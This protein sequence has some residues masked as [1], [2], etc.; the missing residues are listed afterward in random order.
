MMNPKCTFFL[1][2]LLIVVFTCISATAQQQSKPLLTVADTPIA[3]KEFKRV[4]SKNLDLVKDEAQKDVDQYLQLFI[5][6]KLK[7]KEAVA[8]GLDKKQS[9]IDELAK[10]RKQLAS[11]YLSDTKV[12]DALVK[13]AY[14]HMQESV[15]ASHILIK[16]KPNA[17][18][19]DTLQ[20]YNSILQARKR[21]LDGEDFMVVAKEVSQD[22][23]VQK[24]GGDLGWFSAFRMVYPFE[25]NAYDTQVGAVSMPFK[26][27]FGY[28]ILKVN[29]RR[30]TS[31]KV[32]VAHI[33]ISVTSGDKEEETQQR[34]NA[35]HKQLEEGAAFE[36]L[37]K[38]YSDD[39]HSAGQGGQLKKFALGDL[40]A[41]KFEAAAF[42]LTTPG[43]YTQPVRSGFG[44]HIIKLLE[45]HENPT[46]E[47]VKSELAEKIKKDSRSQL[48]TD[49]FFDTLKKNYNL[50]V[51][52]AALYA[53]FKDRIKVGDTVKGTLSSQDKAYENTALEIKEAKYTYGDFVAFLNETKKSTIIK[54]VNAYLGKNYD[55]YV[56][57]T[58]LAYY[59]AHLERDNEDF[60]AVMTEYRDG[61]L[62]FDLMEAK[63][64]NAAKTDSVGL[65]S[66][67]EKNQAKYQWPE[68]YKIQKAS[69]EKKE[70][71]SKI[72][73]LLKEDGKSLEEVKVL[74]NSE[75]GANAIFTE[76]TLPKGDPSLPKEFVPEKGTVT[77]FE[78][79]GYF[80]IVKVNEVIPAG[81]KALEETKGRVIND[82]QKQ[83]EEQWLA[84]LRTKYPIKVNAKVLK[85]V[86]KEL[87]R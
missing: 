87:A 79:K 64:W 33:M 45:K 77:L 43:S 2:N 41:P 42:S 23:S 44:W 14:A 69:T 70:V 75:E 68:R 13:E 76:A 35:I 40:K 71:A 31:G 53:F 17:S 59:E 46:F 85:K 57:K 51:D 26:T 4:Y 25:K 84:V 39:R 47:A 12:S 54:D 62:L 34:I 78:D 7:I 10:Y 67:F 73:S 82:F 72:E 21:V 50:T 8:E 16:M 6:Y 20:A 32:T 60:A 1:R 5:D 28:H 66:Y 55:A 27:Q 11:S 61:L 15:N 81:P 56:S 63:I 22:P 49:A 48:I 58:L 83:L 38:Q 18:P 86:K 19:V 80:V 29:D 30:K 24:N 65:H 52:K 9:Y 3:A 37:A 36:T 74:V